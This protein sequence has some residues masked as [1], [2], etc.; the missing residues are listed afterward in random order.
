MHILD[1]NKFVFI[2]HIIVYRTMLKII[3]CRSHLG[4][5]LHLDEISPILCYFQSRVLSVAG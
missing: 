4:H 2:I 1:F 3:V 5:L